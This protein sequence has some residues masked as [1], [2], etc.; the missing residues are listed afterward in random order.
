MENLVSVKLYKMIQVGFAVH[1][2]DKIAKIWSDA[3]GFSNWRSHE[4]SGIDGK[5]N[6]W[7]TKLVISRMGEVDFELIEPIQGRIAQSR[8]LET[9]GE[10]IHHIMFTVDDFDAT[11]S[12]LTGRPGFRVV[13]KTDTLS[14]IEVPGGVTYEIVGFREEPGFAKAVGGKDIVD[15]GELDKIGIAVHDADKIAKEWGTHFGFN[16]WEK[17]EVSGVG[18]DG[19]PWK[20]KILLNKLDKTR[21]EL[22]QPLQ[23]RRTQTEFLE[24][25]GE[26][27]HHIA[28]KV[29]NINASR[30][31]LLARPGF[32]LVAEMPNRLVFILIPGN[33]IIEL[34]PK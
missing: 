2:A 23:G 8:M 4:R 3:F 26:G 24:K 18:E 5:G 33:V 29:P 13:I 7:R 25:H 22:M 14:Y 10:G 28:F 21:F 1:N 15:L 16:N 30:D 11:M 32:S 27:I 20:N 19:N 9:Y 6:P 34:L 31:K 12:Q 17:R